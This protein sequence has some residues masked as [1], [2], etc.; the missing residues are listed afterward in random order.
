MRHPH[1]R[2]S[3]TLGALL[4]GLLLTGCASDQGAQDAERPSFAF[5]GT[6]ERVDSAARTVS[7]TNEDVPGWMAPMTMS[8]AVDPAAV[9][10]QLTP[11][12]R[13]RATVYGGDF[14]TLYGVEVV[15]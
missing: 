7:V 9:L 8:Y 4:I 11:G 14:S 5:S 2:S 6:V 3:G 15:P 12:V 10:D 13:V 1:L